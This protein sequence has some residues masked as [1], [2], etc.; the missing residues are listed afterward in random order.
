[1]DTRIATNAPAAEAA[2]KGTKGGTVAK[3]RG[4]GSKP[5]G[6]ARDTERTRL[7]HVRVDH[8]G[9]EVAMAEQLLDGADVGSAL[10][11]MCRERVAER[12]AG[13][14][15][16]EPCSARR[17]LHGALH[18]GLV[19]V[20]AEDLAGAAIDG[21][22]QRRE[23]PIPSPFAGGMRILPAQPVGQRNADAIAA[24][25]FVESPDP[26]EMRDQWATQPHRKRAAAVASAPPPAH[27]PPPPLRNP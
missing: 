11:Q 25:A 17:L 23:E 8:R 6:R 13:D 14:R 27:Q 18:R 9:L 21:R 19:K 2:R 1:G 10:Q 3:N 7:E 5:V 20:V 22:S 4:S 12:V 26:L 15:L 24:V 16:G